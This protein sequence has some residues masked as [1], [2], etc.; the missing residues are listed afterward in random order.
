MTD[1]AVENIRSITLR[2]LGADY[3]DSFERLL[4]RWWGQNWPDGL[5]QELVRWRYHQRPEGHLTWVACDGN[6][7]VAM[8]DSRLSQ[9]CLDGVPLMVR[10]TADWYCLPEYRTQMLGLRLMRKMQEY[11][12]PILVI[13]GSQANRTLL[14]RL[15]WNQL[16]VARNYILPVTLRGLAA[17]L[18]RLWWPRHEA[19]AAAVW[20]RL[21]YRPPRRQPPLSGGSTCRVIP[22]QADQWFELESAPAS[23]L[24]AR[25][26]QAHWQWLNAMPK[27]FARPLGLLFEADGSTVG[28]S[29]SQ[30]EPAASGLDA[31]ILH[32]QPAY[33]NARLLAWMVAETAAVLAT[34]GADFVRCRVSTPEK[35]DAVEAVGFRFVQEV[36]CFWW[37][38]AG[39][40]VPG[41]ADLGF[42]RGDDA[43]P[44]PALRGRQVLSQISSTREFNPASRMTYPA[45]K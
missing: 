37:S 41:V 2:R 26:D 11:G 5:Q 40:P 9:H 6:E 23:G 44:L 20:H 34:R 43:L 3:R 7:C 13:N 12:D 25:F 30:L 31:H 16:P 15:H 14:S 42:L 38:K 32:V 35:I 18:L 10:E 21:P 39:Q 29:L 1:F 27:S 28:M 17:N 24:A 22:L 36:P 19:L 45:S 8:L 33:Q 4:A